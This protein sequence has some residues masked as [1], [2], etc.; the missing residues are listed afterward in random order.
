MDSDQMGLELLKLAAEARKLEIESFWRR[1]L[2]FWEFI[3]AAFA[4]YASLSK[5]GSAL[6]SGGEALILR[7]RSSCILDFSVLF[8]GS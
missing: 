6:G 8:A 5:G 7:E 2:F 1:S 4:G 3:V